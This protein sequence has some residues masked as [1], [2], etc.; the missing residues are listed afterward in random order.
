MPLRFT[1]RQLEYFVAVGEYGS[2]AQAADHL[3]VS[4]PSIST[5][6]SQLE[7]EFNVQLFVRRHAHGLSLTSAGDSLLISA[8]DLLKAAYR[9]SV[10]AGDMAET[11]SGPLNVGCLQTF[12][13]MV[14]PELR[15][16][17]EQAYPDVAVSQSTGDHQ[18]LIDGLRSA[19]LDI[20]LTYD[21]SVPGGIVFEPL[22]EV[23]AY[24]MLPATHALAGEAAIAVEALAEDPMVLLDLPV[25]AD[26]FLSVLRDAGIQPN[27][28]ERTQDMALARSMVANGFG[29]TLANFRPRTTLSPDGKPLSFVPLLGENRPLKIGI[30]T[31]AAA[32]KSRV[33][34]AFEEH[35]RDTISADRVPGVVL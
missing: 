8:Q 11:I 2:I 10:M 5:A 17:F 12:A 34:T 6:I 31:N 26:Y 32:R 1:L 3:N 30:A 19:D 16:R 29:Y 18:Y 33:V 27:I 14:F 4:P 20:C 22:V 24:V 13:P 23:P 21:L 7:A 25:S 28:V 9:I 15:S 35:C